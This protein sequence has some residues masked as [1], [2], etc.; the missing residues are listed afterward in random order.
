MAGPN[1]SESVWARG[2]SDTKHALGTWWFWALE[3]FGAGSIGV[4]TQDPVVGLIA[5]AAIAAA[6]WIGATAGA[7]VRQRN[8]QREHIRNLEDS[9]SSRR[10][11]IKREIRPIGDDS[12]ELVV[13]VHNPTSNTVR[14]VSASLLRV[15][16]EPVDVEHRK[17]VKKLIGLPLR[18][19]GLR[20]HHSPTPQHIN[21]QPDQTCG[22]DIAKVHLSKVIA[23]SVAATTQA[24]NGTGRTVYT[25]GVDRGIPLPQGSSYKISIIIRGDDISAHH[26]SFHVDSGRSTVTE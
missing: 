5:V 6:L 24:Q 10:V 21:V 25:H 15:E 8:E 20:N 19:Q 4:Y 26:V 12:Y 18:P 3:V 11:E 16:P 22:F 23:L 13:Y 9:L 2:W 1:L 7:P 17:T 14:N